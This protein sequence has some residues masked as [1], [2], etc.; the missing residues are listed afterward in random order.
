M[1]DTHAH[2]SDKDFDADRN[3]ALQR[4]KEA[5]VKKIICILCEFGERDISVFKELLT[6]DF[7]FGAIAIHP[8][9]AKDYNNRKDEFLKALEI[10][11]VVAI[12]EMGLDYHYALSPKETQIEVFE[13]QLLMAKEKDMP[14]IVHS[15]EAGQDTLEIIKKHRPRKAVMHCFSGDEKEAK[16]YLDM[17]FYI[18]FA[19]P[20]TFK[21][22]LKPK[23]VIKT[24]PDDRLLLE[25][26]C[27]W[28][29]PQVFR[30]KRNEPAYIKSLY[31]ETAN[32]RNT[33]VD[34][35][36]DTVLKNASQIFGIK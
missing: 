19:G 23:E 17:G 35:L 4:A 16:E 6:H 7:I 3:E 28:L 9:D 11:K 18:S 1:V 2:L 34:K 13:K 20:V 24:I 5:G 15:R 21:N 10:P 14:V 25:T 26:D 27:P 31:E 33:T 36:A 30:G 12:G 22:A 8:H 32:L 29:A